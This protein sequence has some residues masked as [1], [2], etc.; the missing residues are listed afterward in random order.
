LDGTAFTAPKKDNV[1]ARQHSQNVAAGQEEATDYG[2]KEPS[3]VATMLPEFDIVYGHMIEFFHDLQIV[4]SQFYV[5]TLS[6][7]ELSLVFLEL[8]KDL[9]EGLHLQET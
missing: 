4:S 9:L 1:D 5:S 6:Q 7:N 2:I 8:P 3:L